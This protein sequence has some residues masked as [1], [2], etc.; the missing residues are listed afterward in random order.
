[1]YIIW[2]YCWPWCALWRVNSRPQGYK[3]ATFHRYSSSH[4]RESKGMTHVTECTNILI[5][6]SPRRLMS[7]STASVPNFMCQGIEQVLSRQAGLPSQSGLNKVATSWKETERDLSR[8]MEIG[9]LYVRFAYALL[10][11]CL[12]LLLWGWE[13]QREACWSRAFID[14]EQRHF[15]F[16]LPSH[17]T[18]FPILGQFRTK[19]KWLPG[20]FQI[21]PVCLSASR[22]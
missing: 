20:E 17:V 22:V 13:F 12:S 10:G 14:G 9:F 3:N 21:S 2:H 11:A 4:P 1:M 19:F 6:R 15:T 8:Y 16:H 5:F 7:H 18:L